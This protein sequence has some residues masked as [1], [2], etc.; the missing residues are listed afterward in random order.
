M[1]NDAQERVGL[2]SGPA[3]RAARDALGWSRERLSRE[4]EGQVSSSHIKGLEGKPRSD[5]L[6]STLSILAHALQVSKEN[7][8]IEGGENEN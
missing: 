2:L 1:T 7:L 8:I 6:L 3:L 5:V 4:T